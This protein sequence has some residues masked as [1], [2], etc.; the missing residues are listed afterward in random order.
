MQY[1]LVAQGSYPALVVALDPGDKLVAEAGAMSWMDPNIQVK[2]SMRGGMGGALKRKFLGGESFFQNEYT[3]NVAGAQI[4]LV[5]GQPGDIRATPMEGERLM[6]ERGAYLAS[7]P[8]VQIDSK[9]QGLKGLFSEGMFVLQASGSGILFWNS[10]GDVQEVQVAGDYVVDNG[11]AVAWDASLSYT[12]TR[13]GK[14][15]RSFLFSDQLVM[16]FSGHGRVWVQSRS[17]YSLAS[18]VHPFRRVRSS[19]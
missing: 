1:Q 15:I 14:K 16:R 7:T 5:A 2:T 8:D 12:V 18:W 11:Y 3:S 10:Y 6:L 9:F 19:N 17:P 13:S 4:T